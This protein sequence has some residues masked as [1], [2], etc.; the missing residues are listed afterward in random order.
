MSHTLTD[1]DLIVGYLGSSPELPDDERAKLESWILAHG[2]RSLDES[3]ARVWAQSDNVSSSGA[4]MKGLVRLL[5]STQ[6]ADAA[7][8]RR[9]ERK[10]MAR[11]R[12]M[13]LVA[14]AIVMVLGIYCIVGMSE[15]E[16]DYVLITA[17]DSTGEFTLPDGSHVWLNGDTR[18]SYNDDFTDGEGRRVKISG[19]A[20]FDVAKDTKRPF[21]VDMGELEVEVLGTS[22]EVRNYAACRLHDIVLREGSLKVRGPWGDEVTMKPDEML[23]YDPASGSRE[24]GQ[25]E[26]DNY[27]RW[28]ERY[29]TFDNTP[30]ADILV[31]VSRR[32]GV[33]L[34]IAPEV[35]AECMLSLTMGGES[36]QSIM[37]TLSYISDISYKIEGKSLVI[38]PAR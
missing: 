29:V 24:V 17:A 4:R 25:V 32:Y 3:F 28:F 6:S 36:L 12:A 15:G 18:L 16:R 33:D 5:Q 19:E 13:S 20:Y 2:G 22:F 7:T 23:S 37:N 35:D 26:A 11:W 34:D 9:R 10:M 31:H 8:S 38:E 14:L 21:V 30:L 27:C 1:C